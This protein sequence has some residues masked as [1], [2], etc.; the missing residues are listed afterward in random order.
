MRTESVCDH[1]NG[2]ESWGLYIREKRPIAAKQRRKSTNSKKK[3]RS[4][5]L[6]QIPEQYLE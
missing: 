1:E 4:E 2:S 6:E 5:I 3:A